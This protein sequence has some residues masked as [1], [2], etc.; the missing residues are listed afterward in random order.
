MSKLSKNKIKRQTTTDITLKKKKVSTASKLTHVAK[1]HGKQ[2]LKKVLLSKLFHT[3]FKVFVGLLIVGAS[4]YGCYAYFTKSFANDVVVSKSEIV[5]RVS[6]LINLP[7]GEPEAVVRVEDAETLKKQ[8]IFY[9]NIKSG[10]Y[11]IMYPKMAIIYDLLNNS[12]VSIKKTDN[13]Q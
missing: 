8:N 6:K 13:T 4:L 2:I 11:I 1:R 10:D 7:D 3:T 12:I 5:D 9:E